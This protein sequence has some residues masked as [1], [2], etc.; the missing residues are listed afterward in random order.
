MSYD[1]LLY[2]NLKA[3][4]SVANNVELRYDDTDFYKTHHL[5]YDINI[6]DEALKKIVISKVADEIRRK[7]N[8]DIVSVKYNDRTVI[9]HFSDGTYTKAV[10]T[11]ND[12]FNLDYGIMVCLLRKMTNDSKEHRSYKR[13]MRDIRK[14]ATEIVQKPKKKKK[15]A[16]VIE[17]RREDCDADP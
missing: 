15:E 11:E 16:D 6:D 14:T 3:L 17:Q 5:T 8:L 13:M 9:M 12:V 10:C 7:P 2:D 1:K 4:Q